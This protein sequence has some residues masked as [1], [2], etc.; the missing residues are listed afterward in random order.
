[1]YSLALTL[2][3]AVRF[4]NWQVDYRWGHWLGLFVW[5]GVIW[6]AHRQISRRLPERDPFLFP[7]AAMLTGWGL[8]TIWRLSSVQ[9]LRQ[10]AW[11]VLIAMVLILAIHYDYQQAGGLAK[12]NFE[13]PLA[14]LFA[15]L[16]QHE[17][18]RHAD[19]PFVVTVDDP[20]QLAG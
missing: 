16:L 3:N 2:S 8:L 14:Q 6:L 15:R 7:I 12:T 11:L 13:H 10:T 9:A 17:F 4:H 19:R 1:M 5:V 20:V 18:V